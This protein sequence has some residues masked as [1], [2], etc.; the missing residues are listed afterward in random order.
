MD[1]QQGGMAQLEHRDK[2]PRRSRQAVVRRRV[3][4]R[5]QYG[6]GEQRAARRRAVVIRPDHVVHWKR[7]ESHGKCSTRL[8]YEGVATSLSGVFP[9][10]RCKV[11]DDGGTGSFVGHE[12][13]GGMGCLGEFTRKCFR[14]FWKEQGLRDRVLVLRETERIR[15]SQDAEGPRH[16]T[17][18]GF[19]NG[20][21]HRSKRKLKCKRHKRGMF[22]LDVSS[23]EASVFEASKKGLAEAGCVD[24][25][26]A[27]LHALEIGAVLLLERNHEMQCGVEPC[28][29]VIVFAHVLMKVCKP[30]TSLHVLFGSGCSQGERQAPREWQRRAKS[31][32]RCQRPAT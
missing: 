19:E 6:C 28:A 17:V 7:L 18:E 31:W 25:V 8:E 15:M 26:S 9:E 11:D 23:R 30:A 27:D 1:R 4:C 24:M 10:E 14:E 22:G 3:E 29:A 21:Q 32:W 2:S 20:R 12:R 13:C 16:V 5:E